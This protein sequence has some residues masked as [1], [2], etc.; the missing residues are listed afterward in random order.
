MLYKVEENMMNDVNPEFETIEM[1]LN[2]NVQVS[3]P[4]SPLLELVQEEPPPFSNDL[5]PPPS[6]ISPVGTLLEYGNFPPVTWNPTKSCSSSPKPSGTPPSPNT[7]S[8]TESTQPQEETDEEDQLYFEG[9]LISKQEAVK[10]I[11][12]AVQDMGKNFFS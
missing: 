9:N 6:P 10:K 11:I 5:Q 3:N 8:E 7:P 1:D 12:E 2:Y 4:F